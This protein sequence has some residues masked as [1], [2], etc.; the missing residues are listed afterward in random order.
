MRL[1]YRYRRDGKYYIQSACSIADED[2]MRQELKSFRKI[3]DSFQK[4]VIVGDDIATYTNDDGFIFM[5]LMQF[6]END[7][8]L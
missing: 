5:G 8:I 1:I 4:I 2:K 6:L 7:A 3:D